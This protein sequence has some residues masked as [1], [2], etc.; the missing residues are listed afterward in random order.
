MRNLWFYA[1]CDVTN[2]P[3]PSQE[4][5]KKISEAMARFGDFYVLIMT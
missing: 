5:G 1:I 4:L 2:C 3:L